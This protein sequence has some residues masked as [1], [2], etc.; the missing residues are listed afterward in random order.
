[1]V[2]TRGHRNRHLH[3]ACAAQAIAMSYED[4]AVF[5]RVCTTWQRPRKL[6]ALERTKTALKLISTD[7][8]G[9]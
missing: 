1:M 8:L 4:D 9:N 3:S 7:L 2:S 6:F 5:S